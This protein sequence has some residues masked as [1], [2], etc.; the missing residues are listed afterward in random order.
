MT[1]VAMT[2][3]HSV[4]YVP[5]ASTRTREPRHHVSHV[6]PISTLQKRGLRA[7]RIAK[8]IRSSFFSLSKCVQGWLMCHQY[9]SFLFHQA[10]LCEL[11]KI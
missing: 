6:V 8:V 5:M 9:S 3:V 11:N 10:V 4:F 1:P 7:N 2:T